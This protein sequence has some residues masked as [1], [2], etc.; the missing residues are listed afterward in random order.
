M[1]AGGVE[2]QVIPQGR[3][4]LPGRL[5]VAVLSALVLFVTASRL[6]PA[7][8][9]GLHEGTRGFWVATGQHCER[10]ACTWNGQFTL[11]DG[12]VVLSSAQYSG[13][14]P[15][16][17]HAGTHLAALFPG[18]SA[19][20]YPASGSDAWISLLFGLVLAVIGLYWSSHRFVANYL[21]NRANS[22][23]TL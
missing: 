23:E 5:I 10:S 14:L 18:G 4:R 12:R 16:G 8:R 15:A 19:L 2:P 11:P 22:L 21:R 6:M 9:A 7:I 1:N 20:V 3:S 13:Q 17:I